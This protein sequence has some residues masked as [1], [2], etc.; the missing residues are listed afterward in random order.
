M[1]YSI[2]YYVEFSLQKTVPARHQ[3]KFVIIILQSKESSV[4]AKKRIQIVPKIKTS[5]SQYK[6]MP[7]SFIMST[8]GC[9]KVEWVHC[10]FDLLLNTLRKPIRV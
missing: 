9:E 3:V 5:M 8:N 6:H 4:I 2:I 7:C 1:L 10:K